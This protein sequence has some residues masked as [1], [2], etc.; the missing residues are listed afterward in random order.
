M[1]KLLAQI[2]KPQTLGRSAYE[3]VLYGSDD[4]SDS[5]AEDPTEKRKSLGRKTSKKSKGRD[6]DSYLEEEED[7]PLDLMDVDLM[8]RVTGKHVPAV[9]E[10]VVQ[11]ISIYSSRPYPRRR[12]EKPYQSKTQKLASIARLVKCCCSILM[13]P[14]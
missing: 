1:T 13:K 6:F 2:S 10:L 14:G 3:D 7:E 11:R 12:A 4:E 8:N 5:S 9:C